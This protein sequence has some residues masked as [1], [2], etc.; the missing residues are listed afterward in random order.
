ML[1]TLVEKIQKKKVV[2][3]ALGL[4]RVGLPLASVFATRGLKVIGV[5]NDESR[6]NSIRN[7][8]CPFYDP[9]LKKK[10]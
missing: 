6:L 5:D 2:I 3:C 7:G 1:E 4:G 9:T 10:S 8:I